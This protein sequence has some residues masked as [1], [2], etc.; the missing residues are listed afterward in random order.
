MSINFVILYTH[1][2]FCSWWNSMV[3]NVLLSN[4]KRH[5]WAACLRPWIHLFNFTREGII[6]GSKTGGL[7]T[8][9]SSCRGEYKNAVLMSIVAIWRDSAAAMLRRILMLRLKLACLQKTEIPKITLGDQSC[10][11]FVD[12]AENNLTVNNF[13]WKYIGKFYWR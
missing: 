7:F 10:F 8:Y 4:N 1:L 6:L 5:S 11:I 12:S 2:S 9:N 13:W 3:Y